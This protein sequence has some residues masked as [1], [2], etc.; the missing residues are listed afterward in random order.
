M[1]SIIKL[2]FNHSKTTSMN[3]YSKK[4]TPRPYVYHISSF[5]NRASIQKNGLLGKDNSIIG[6][7]NAVFAHN[8]CEVSFDW[9]P[10]NIDFMEA[11]FSGRLHYGLESEDPIL[12]YFIALGYDVWRI[13]TRALK[14]N[15]FVDEIA[16]EDF[17]DGMSYPYYVVTFGNIPPSALKLVDIEN[18]I[19]CYVN[20]GV[21]N[22]VNE[23]R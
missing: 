17:L 21:A 3:Q 6:Y 7:K 12:L 13:D 11:C 14:Q 15:W 20:N 23:F 5:R 4:I 2:L 18:P 8:T 19:K 16:Q 10:F 9:H 1:G 22:I